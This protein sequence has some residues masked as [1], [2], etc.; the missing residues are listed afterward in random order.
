MPTAPTLLRRLTIVEYFTFGFGSMVGVGWL[1]LID[2]WLGRGGPGAAMLGFLAGGLLLLPVA[3]TYGVLV[4]RIP[5]AGAEVAYT[6]GVFPPVLSFA[7]GWT[8]VLAYAIVC[9]WEAVAIGN[10][11]G[12]IV[13]AVNTFP[14][15]TIAGKT[16]F[17]P[18]VAAGLLL[19]GLVAWVNV[20]GIRPS[21]QFQNLTTF[22]LLAAFAVF[23]SL[24]FARGDVSNLQ[25]LFSRPGL[26]GGILSVILAAQI[27]PYFMTGFE[28]VVKGAEEARVGFPPRDFAKAMYAAVVAAVV[29]YVVIVAVVSYVYPWREIVAGHVGTEA[30]FERAFGS[31][32]I[33]R[34]I[35]AGAFLSLLKV[36]NGN[37]VAATRLLFAMGRRGLVHRGL[38]RVHGSHGTPA[39]AIWM[40][41]ALTAVASLLG[42]ALLV[43]I[44]E[45][46]SLAAGIGW[47]SA[48]A[49]CLARREREGR[50]MAAAGVLVSL[51]LIA[52][53]VLPFVPGSFTASEWV[54]LGLWMGLGLTL[55]TLRVPRA[56][57]PS[58]DTRE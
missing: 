33:A 49:A 17:A 18:R 20:R 11:L 26:A 27:V 2:D 8:M 3:A 30:A 6:E 10:L 54:A 19:T 40:L 37:F 14:L 25:P 42:D 13:P 5:D 34:L 41:A 38:G 24:G 9:P 7:A 12:R 46:G 45:V 57:T 43:P 39:V 52:M 32:Q 22:G 35:L 56:G 21:G 48:C 50:T 44:T 55:W 29:F 23:V 4:R 28:S 31:H 58:P 47:L 16:I 15:Y 53:K 36:F 51:V 1:V